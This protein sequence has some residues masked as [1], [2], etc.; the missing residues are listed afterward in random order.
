MAAF[1]AFAFVACSSDSDSGNSGSQAADTPDTDTKLEITSD[2]IKSDGTLLSKTAEVQVISASTTITGAA[3]TN[4][5]TEVF[6]ADRTV[7]LSPFIMGK[8]QVTQEL[9]EKVMTGQKVTVSGTEYALDASPSYCTASSTSYVLADGETAKYR[10]VE[11]VTWYDA[12]YFCNA[13][14]ENLGLTKAY[15]IEV[16]TVSA[17]TDGHIT[18]ATVTPVANANGYRL[19]TEA[20]WEFTARGGNTSA[21]AWNYLFSGAD[22]G[23]KSTEE[24]A[25]A[26]TYSD[27]KNT[28]LD[29]VGWYYYNLGGTTADTALSSSSAGY[30]TH[31]VGKK[32][33]NAL[34]IYDMS[35]NVWEWC[36][37][38]YDT[39]TA[40]E[41]GVT[42][43]SGAASGSYRVFRGGSWY[44]DA[45]LASVS[46]RGG[47]A[48]SGR[49]ILLGLPPLSLR[50]VTPLVKKPIARRRKQA[51]ASDRARAIG[52]LQK[53]KKI[54][55]TR[56]CLFKSRVSG[57]FFV[58]KTR[59]YATL[60]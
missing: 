27:S 8:Y 29:T 23:K 32:A 17:T 6:P 56:K 53:I 21:E 40:E 43:P 18:A 16:T 10:P 13:L 49:R 38:W 3:Y 50:F 26:A 46:S 33:A 14:S 5:Y 24:N 37:D 9:Y 1:A 51:V 7:T 42:D 48:P 11:N 54:S 4:N 47:D 19:P 28:G 52:I 20:E 55:H 35:G 25:G 59:G 2:G 44:D 31:E 34:G 15:T 41:N 36:Y 45:D 60:F 30:G 22:T 12:V 39:I 57:I 58:T